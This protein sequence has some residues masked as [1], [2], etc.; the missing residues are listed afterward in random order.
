MEAI[1]VDSAGNHGDAERLR[2]PDDVGDVLGF[3]ASGV[4]GSE[5]VEATADHGLVL[6][7]VEARRPDRP[8]VL[9]SSDRDGGGVRDPRHNALGHG[10][11]A[12]I[13]QVAVDVV[14][15][16]QETLLALTA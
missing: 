10:D 13:D 3:Q 12:K 16:E 6:D 4:V 8:S 14:D 1:S 2:E 15:G 5:P 11:C 9:E 7:I